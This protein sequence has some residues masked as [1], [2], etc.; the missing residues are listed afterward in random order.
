MRAAIYTR[1]STVQQAEKHGTAYQ[2]RALRSLAAQRGWEVAYHFDDLGFSGRTQKRP[3]L[4]AL[5]TAMHRGKVDAV[6]VWRFD[7]LARSISDLVHF[8][9]D[10]RARNIAF[11]SYTENIDTSTP[12]GMALFHIAGAMAQLESDLAR[13]RVR[14]GMEAA[15]ARGTHIGRPRC[16]AVTVRG[17]LDAVDVYGGVR[18]AARALEV[19]PSLISRRL[20]EAEANG[21]RVRAS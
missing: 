16:T 2:E 6:A 3:G 4:A 15:R 9:E 20:R 8:L 17:A 14:A 18:A 7:R 13:E 12:L 21:L 5:K 10:C 19:S 11:V 1:V